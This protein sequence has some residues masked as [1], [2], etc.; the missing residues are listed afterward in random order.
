[1]SS[2]KTKPVFGDSSAEVSL[3]TGRQNLEIFPRHAGNLLLR[4]VGVRFLGWGRQVQLLRPAEH[5]LRPLFLLLR[6]ANAVKRLRG[7]GRRRTHYYAL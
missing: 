3:T 6:A 7:K 5:C 4:T 2:R 1:M